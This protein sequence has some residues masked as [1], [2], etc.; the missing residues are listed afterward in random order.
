MSIFSRFRHGTRQD[1][2][3]RAETESSVTDEFARHEREHHEDDN[4]FSHE[5]REAFVQDNM[6]NF[7]RGPG[8]RY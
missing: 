3:A 5:S 7:E 1:G 4:F 2:V 6:N 8:L